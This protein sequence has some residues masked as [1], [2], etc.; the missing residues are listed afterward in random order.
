[1]KI[2][3]D[4]DVDAAYIQLAD[5]IL[6]GQSAEQIHSIVTPGGNGELTL[7]FDAGGR[8]LGIEILRAQAVLPGSV[9]Q[10][11]TVISGS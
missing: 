9:I 7:D 10:S 6:P 4:P 1:M 3:Y 8:L 5:Q 2:T 11:A